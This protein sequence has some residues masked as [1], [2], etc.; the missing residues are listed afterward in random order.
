MSYSSIQPIKTE[1]DFQTWKLYLVTGNIDFKSY[2][3]Q[4]AENLKKENK[5]NNLWFVGVA[6]REQHE[7]FL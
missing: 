4:E 3:F 2:L 7:G 1:Q 5:F 6:V